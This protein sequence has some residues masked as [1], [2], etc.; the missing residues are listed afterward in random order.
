MA[1]F[2]AATLRSAM[3]LSHTSCAFVC[4]VIAAA[5]HCR[6]VHLLRGHV[7]V[8]DSFHVLPGFPHQEELPVSPTDGGLV[9]LHTC[10]AAGLLICV[11]TVPGWVK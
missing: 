2:H 6:R 1:C 7:L 5:S 4:V 9:S 11:L 8:R 10:E 3:S